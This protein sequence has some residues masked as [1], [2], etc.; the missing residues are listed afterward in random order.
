MSTAA[1]ARRAISIVAA[2]IVATLCILSQQGVAAEPAKLVPLKTEL[3]KPLFVGTPKNI[4]PSSNMEKYSEKPKAPLMIP[5][6]CTNL[7]LKAKVTSSDASPII[8]ELT[9][10]TDGDKDGGDGSFVELA[11]GKQWLQVDLGKSAD[12]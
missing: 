12:L 2:S 9:L 1:L 6:G 10:A 11:P 3:P 8:G 5:D 7:A 4:K